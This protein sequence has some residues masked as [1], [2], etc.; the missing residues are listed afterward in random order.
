MDPTEA[1]S[2][3]LPFLEVPTTGK[4]IPTQIKHNVKAVR[5]SECD[6]HEHEEVTPLDGKVFLRQY[7]N[8]MESIHELGRFTQLLQCFVDM[9]EH[10]KLNPESCHEAEFNDLEAS[11][12]L[13]TTL[14]NY[15]FYVAKPSKTFSS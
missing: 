9:L 13:D 15:H 14:L 5:E 12:V 10:Q 8:T 4:Q 11:K 3:D 6:K 1:T 7:R 2:F